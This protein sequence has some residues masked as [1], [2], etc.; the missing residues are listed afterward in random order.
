M[1][2]LVEART[3]ATQSSPPIAHASDPNITRLTH[4][5]YR[6]DR[7]GSKPMGQRALIS[8][9]SESLQITGPD[10]LAAASLESWVA[11][12]ET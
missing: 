1:F 3:D 10:R 12:E 9:T 11:A 5:F 7:L 4:Q 6:N 8:H 2:A